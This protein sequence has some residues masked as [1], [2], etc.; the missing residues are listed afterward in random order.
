MFKRLLCLLC[1]VMLVF[2]LQPAKL[3]AA[4]NI[5]LV[6]S[7]TSENELLYYSEKKLMLDK[8]WYNYKFEIDEQK[9]NELTTVDQNEYE[10]ALKSVTYPQEKIKDYKIYFLASSLKDYPTTVALTFHD[11]SSVVFGTF[12]ALSKETIHHLAVHELGHQVDFQ[13]MDDAKWYQF[14]KLRG[15]SN[16]QI[17][18]NYGEIYENRPQEI[19]AEDFR[20]LFCGDSLNQ[21]PHLN[22]TLIKPE[23]VAGLKEFFLS[24]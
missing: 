17:Y 4:E 23:L 1:F 18:N 14:K 8:K 20:L 11:N 3:I 2:H 22:K 19:F 10:T 6:D 13:L 16:T 24:L 21:T 12:T 5:K 9:S 15:I 7:H